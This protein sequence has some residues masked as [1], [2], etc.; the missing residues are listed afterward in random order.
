MPKHD[1]KDNNESNAKCVQVLMEAEKRAREKIE[2]SRIKRAQRLK[3]SRNEAQID[4]ERFKRLSEENFNKSNRANLNAHET[5][6]AKYERIT[7]D[8]ISSLLHYYTRNKG[9]TLQMIMK[10]ILLIRPEFHENLF[11]KEII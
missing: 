4:I 11:P 1:K 3:V 9:I 6:V 2:Q 8:S 7:K 10:E 5:F